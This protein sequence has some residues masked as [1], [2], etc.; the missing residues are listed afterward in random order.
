VIQRRLTTHP[1]GVR[2]HCVWASASR[3]IARALLVSSDVH[4]ILPL[5]YLYTYR[6]TATA[7]PSIRSHDQRHTH[8]TLLAREHCIT[9][10]SHHLRRA[11]IEIARKSYARVLQ[12]DDKTPG[13]GLD[14]IVG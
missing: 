6:N 9:A 3:L 1:P 5:R 12:E 11:S 8:T 2:G 4:H 14:G 10:V 7:L 13:T